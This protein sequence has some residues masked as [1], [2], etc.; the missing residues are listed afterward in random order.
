[1]PVPGQRISSSNILLYRE[2]FHAADSRCS[3][4]RSCWLLDTLHYLFAFPFATCPPCSRLWN[5]F[6]VPQIC[7]CVFSHSIPSPWVMLLQLHCPLAKSFQSL[8]L[9][10]KM[11]SSG[12]SLLTILDE[13]GG[14]LARYSTAPVLSC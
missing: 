14:T 1:M 8:G 9:S 3:P 2:M 12:K 11:A 10:W 4:Q 6:W 7:P 5:F 13:S